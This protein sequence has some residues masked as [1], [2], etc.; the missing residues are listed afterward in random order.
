MSRYFA[1]RKLKWRRLI[2]IVAVLISASTLFIFAQK[3][4]DSSPQIRPRRVSTEMGRVVELRA[5]GDLQ[6][7]INAAQC[8][9]SV[10][11]QAGAT[12][13]GEFVL[14]NRN[15][16]ASTPIRIGSSAQ[17]SLPSGRVGPADATNMPRIRAWGTGITGSA[18]TMAA[19]SGYWVLDGLELTDNAAA[20]AIVNAL[21]TVADSTS[22]HLT[23]QRCYF[24]QKETGTNYNRSVIRGIQFEGIDLTFKWNYVYIIG[25]YNSALGNGTHYQMDSTAVLSVAS[26]GPL[27]IEDNYLSTWWNNIFLGGSDTAPQNSATL[28]NATT[29][30]ATFSNTTGLSPGV[31]LRL[32][33]SG[34]GTLNTTGLTSSCTTAGGGWP[35]S[36]GEAN[37]TATFTQTSGTTLSAADVQRVGLATGSPD[38]GLFGVCAVSGNVITVAKVRT[39]FVSAGAVT[40]KLYE[41]AIVTSVVGATVNYTPTGVNSLQANGATSASWNYGDQGLINDVTVRRNTFYVDPVFAHD[42]YV[43]NHYS[44]KGLYELKN[45]NRFTFEGNRVLGYPA[46]MAIYP[47]NQSGS[48]PWITG[49]HIIIRNN[50]IAPDLGYPESTREAMTIV[51][52]DNYATITPLQDAQVYNNLIKNTSSFL[53]MKQMD[54]MN[55]YHNT[56]INTG[57]TNFSYN[58][59]ITGIE[60]VTNFTFRDNIVAYNAYG[61]NCSIPPGGL[62]TCWPASTFLNNVVVG[63]VVATSGGIS[64]N[65][66]GTGSI[67][68]PIVSNFSRVGFTDALSH[69]YR[70]TDL[71]SYKG[72]ASDRKDPGVDMDELL[73]ALPVGDASKE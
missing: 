25:Y 18:F 5:G 52:Q 9:D 70:L 37:S 6:R 33:L 20:T 32:E 46:V 29:R 67:L 58:D 34:A 45:I 35:T 42:M 61:A 56:V 1:E 30:S 27:L 63:D 26:P 41:T 71:S 22:H 72:K 28:S 60:P 44:P 65:Q 57:P 15:C 47:T 49:K 59:T 7:A 51:N 64:T 24:H 69:N 66:W 38:S 68:R 39:A 73:S 2:L 11:L 31:M 40:W 36:S 16:T 12:W 4:R 13:D 8:G 48:A 23:V 62:S 50:W 19:N 10:V 53:S 43:Q 17:A 14:P 3:R 55:V 21:V 54:G